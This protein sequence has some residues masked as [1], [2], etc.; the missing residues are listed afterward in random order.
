MFLWIYFLLSTVMFTINFSGQGYNQ[1]YLRFILTLFPLSMVI[2]QKLQ[3]RFSQN[4]YLSFSIL[5]LFIMTGLF[6]NWYKLGWS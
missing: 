1:G 6:A 3:S 2:S 5:M 4:A